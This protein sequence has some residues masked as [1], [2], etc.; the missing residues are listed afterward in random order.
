MAEIRYNVLM[1]WVSRV[2]IGVGVVLVAVGLTVLLWPLHA[3]GV[4]GSALLPHY[5][6]ELGFQTS[7]ALPLHP[8]LGEL[9]LAGVRL[10]GDVVAHRRRL[11]ELVGGIG[12]ALVVVSS[13][14]AAR[15]RRWPA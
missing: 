13:V 9:R 14:F 8:T 5:A 15:H 6:K 10:P 2:I 12:L 1:R 4:S 11:G 3:N 7:Y